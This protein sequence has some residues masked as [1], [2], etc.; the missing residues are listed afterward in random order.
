MKIL[1]LS[2]LNHDSSVTIFES[3]EIVKHFLSERITK[4]KKDNN[5]NLIISNLNEKVY[6][7]ISFSVFNKNLFNCQLI[8]KRSQLFLNETIE[9]SK[10]SINLNMENHHLSHAYLAYYTSKFDE[11]LCFVFDGNGSFFNG[12]VD[13]EWCT[14]VE[15]VYRFKRGKYQSQ[16]F[17]RYMICD[18]FGQGGNILPKKT[19]EDIVNK[20]YIISSDLSIGIIYELTTIEN[21]F[22]WNEGGKTMGLSQYVNN[23]YKLPPKYNNEEWKNKVKRSNE[24]QK[25]VEKRILETVK[26]YVDDTGIKNVIITGGVAL[27][28]VSNY[29]LLKEIEDINLHIDPICDDGGISIG[30]A[31]QTYIE[32]TKKNP[33][34]IANIYLGYEENLEELKEKVK[35]FDYK[36]VSYED[37]IKII[38]Q[39]KAV[40]LFQGKSESGAR[41]LGNRSILF[42][43]RV[44][45]GR[46][47]VNEIKKREDYRP[48]AASIL[49]EHVQEWFDLKNLKESPTMSFAVDAYK[50]TIKTVPSVI[51]VDNTSRIQTVTKK[52]NYH[53]YN[54]IK[55]FYNQ[56]KV[57][58][59][60]NTSFN[61]SGKPLVETFDDA[62]NA[63]CNS[64]IEYLYLPEIETLVTI[65]N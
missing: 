3:G 61:L 40:S 65:K 27:N 1:S 8:D 36:K 53:F 37:I 22:N 24:S 39:K 35:N 19:I 6:D 45:N 7:L 47:I 44:K 56:T 26:K 58:M 46:T 21:G 4:F 25:K 13:N 9:K 32:N 62:I 17:K 15:S 57:P 48:F 28:C 60:L 18:F 59:L 12:I 14:E 31:I 2:L 43:P 20:N 5:L 63:L 55:E 29:N 33:K 11:C 52:Q 23:I 30:N 50:K 42:D 64:E 51:H 41:A 16:I 38:L 54:L 10:K 49:L 34:R